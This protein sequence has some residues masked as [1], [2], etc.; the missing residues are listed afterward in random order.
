MKFS[1]PSTWP[2]ILKHG[3]APWLP[4]VCSLL[5]A[6][7]FTVPAQAQSAME[8]A[9][10]ILQVL[11]P[12]AAYTTTFI[13]KDPEGRKQFYYSFFCTFTITQSLKYSINSQRPEGNG[14]HS[15]PSGHTSA[16][17][18][19]ATFLQR[20]YGW[21]YGLPAYIGAAF[22]GYS[23]VEGE[24]D[25]HYPGDVL[26]GAAL[27][28]ISGYYFTESPK[29]YSKSPIIDQGRYGVSFKLKW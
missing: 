3:T 25:K 8:Q 27:G 9:G 1:S 10:D 18:Q 13:K 14:G 2:G 24:L 26:A 12:S 29:S 21:G 15:F 20:R 28:I 4:V 23:R 22:V 11:I 6:V 19:G 5:A 7:P 16:A 17:F